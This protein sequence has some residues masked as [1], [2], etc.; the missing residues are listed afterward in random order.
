VCVEVGKKDNGKK[1]VISWDIQKED[2]ISWYF[3]QNNYHFR[4]PLILDLT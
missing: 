1:A 4:N 3:L 2:K